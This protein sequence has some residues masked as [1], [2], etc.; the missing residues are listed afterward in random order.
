MPCA[1][2]DRYTA[3]TP[4]DL[5]TRVRTGSLDQKTSA[6]GRAFSASSRFARPVDFV[7]SVSYNT[8]TR[9]PDRRS[10]SRMT[11]SENGRSAETYAVT[12]RNDSLLFSSVGLRHAPM[13]TSRA[14][15]ETSART[16]TTPL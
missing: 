3:S 8:L 4:L 13:K 16:G 2:G 14:Q 10:Y 11:G 12:S 5:S 7:S 9:T 1:L 6:C 15:H